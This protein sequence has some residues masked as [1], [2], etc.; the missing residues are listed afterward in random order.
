[1]HLYDSHLQVTKEGKIVEEN[2]YR[3]NT[4]RQQLD[5]KTYAD[6]IVSTAIEMEVIVMGERLYIRYI[7]ISDFFFRES[8]E[9]T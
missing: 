9:Q 5:K 4:Q 7:V 1:M 6:S 2:D 3:L 8:A